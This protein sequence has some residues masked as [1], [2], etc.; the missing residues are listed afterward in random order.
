M[1][2]IGQPPLEE[3][4][5][6]LEYPDRRIKAIVYTMISSGTRLG[7]WDYLI[8]RN[9]RPIEKDG[10]IVA[11]KII[12][13]GDDGDDIFNRITGVTQFNWNKMLI[14]MD[15]ESSTAASILLDSISI[16]QNTIL[17]LTSFICYEWWPILISITNLDFYFKWFL[18]A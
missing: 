18:L 8:S 6:L 3:I 5:K 15:D 13:Y 12:V 16:K 7:V 9:I 11:A 1:Q 10:E 2:T 4:Q 17:H 14:R